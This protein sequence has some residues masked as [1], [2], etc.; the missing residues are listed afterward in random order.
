MV[1]SSNEAAIAS[2]LWPRTDY[3]VCLPAGK[4]SF[5]LERTVYLDE[6]GRIRKY[7]VEEGNDDSAYRLEHEYDEQGR[8][9]FS[10][11]TAGAASGASFTERLYFGESGALIGRER[12]EFGGVYEFRPGWPDDNVVRQPD[13]DFVAPPPP[14]CAK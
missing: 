2:G 6:R 3:Q 4:Q 13:L 14:D 12:G 1:I 10:V 5:G 7:V 11:G 8:L 9:R